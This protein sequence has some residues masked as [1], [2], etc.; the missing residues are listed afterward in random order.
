MIGRFELLTNS[1]AEE[2]PELQNVKN[3]PK[4]HIN[5]NGLALHHVTSMS[6]LYDTY[7]PVQAVSQ[8]HQTLQLVC[9]SLVAN[10]M[11]INTNQIL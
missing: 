7:Q 8:M 9:D 3:G 10:K 4:Y 2:A 1:S 11:K 5:L 6:G